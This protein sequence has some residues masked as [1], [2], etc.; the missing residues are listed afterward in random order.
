MDSRDLTCKNKCSDG[1]R[2][3]D[4]AFDVP[5]YNPLHIWEKMI[6]LLASQLGL[7][8]QKSKGEE[9]G[10]DKQKLALWP[11]DRDEQSSISCLSHELYTSLGAQVN[12]FPPR[13]Q[14]KLFAALPSEGW[15]MNYQHVKADSP[16]SYLGGLWT[17]NSHLL[18]GRWILSTDI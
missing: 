10:W 11:K 7:V 12:P 1:R 18:L 16:A 6:P 13:S 2:E 17:F 5:I 9:I 15:S 4:D 3:D 8:T 14:A